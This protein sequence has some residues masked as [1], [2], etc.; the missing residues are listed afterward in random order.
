MLIP[1]HKGLCYYL[2]LLKNNY[3]LGKRHFHG[4]Y[5]ERRVKPADSC[6]EDTMGEEAEEE[7]ST[8][9][10]CSLC[11]GLSGRSLGS[12]HCFSLRSSCSMMLSWVPLT[13]VTARCHKNHKIKRQLR[14]SLMLLWQCNLGSA[15][16]TL[17]WFLEIFAGRK[18]LDH[19][20]SNIPLVATKKWVW[21]EGFGGHSRS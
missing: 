12:D 16:V 10:Q 21:D 6:R 4:G 15:A 11:S 3:R 5:L 13:S 2:N 18:M 9:S 20:A 8:E 7:S 14:K 17:N 19:T 1:R